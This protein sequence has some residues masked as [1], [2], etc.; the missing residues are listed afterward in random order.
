VAE[1]LSNALFDVIDTDGDNE[2][3]RQEFGR[4]LKAWD[5]TDPAAMET[6]TALD[7][8]GDGAISRQELVRAVREFFL[9]NDIEAPG[10]ALFGRATA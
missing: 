3:T 4:Y 7:T 6:C 5:V 8:D 1:G 2:I 10:S 9:S